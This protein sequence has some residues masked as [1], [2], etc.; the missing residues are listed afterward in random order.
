MS[1]PTEKVLYESEDKCPWCS[2]LIR[3]R[4]VRTTLTPGE[5]AET[6]VTGFLEKVTQSTLEEDFNAS[7]TKTKKPVKRKGF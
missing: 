1:K 6:E 3:T 4:V 5:K 7:Q 2:K